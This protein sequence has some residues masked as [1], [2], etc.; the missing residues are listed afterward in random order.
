[1]GLHGVYTKYARQG[2]S[3]DQWFDSYSLEDPGQRTDLQVEGLCE[4][5]AFLRALIKHETS[6]LGEDGHR[7]VILGGLSQGC[8]VAIFTIL[9]GNESDECKVPG[10]FFGMGGWLPFE[11]QLGEILQY[12][13]TQDDTQPE[14]IT[15]EEDDSSNDEVDTDSDDG[16]NGKDAFS[17]IDHGND[18]FSRTSPEHD[19]F[20][21]FLASDNEV[22]R[23]IQALNHIRD[24]LD[25][26]PLD[27]LQYHGQTPIFLGHGSADPKVSVALGQKMARL[28]SEGLEMDVTWKVYEDFGHWYKVPDKIDDILSFLQVKVD[29]PVATVGG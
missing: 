28:L 9:G 2:S 1:M 24:I 25:L 13:Q 8:A 19:D 21:P 7:R 27:E 5:A 18:L 22:P 26:A 15:C 17:D 11:Q 20:D 29:L 23:P 4:T 16:D 12:S 3:C 10:A 6:L 14:T